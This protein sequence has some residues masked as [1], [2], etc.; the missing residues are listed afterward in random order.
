MQSHAKI[1]KEAFSLVELLVVMAIIGVLAS[2]AVPVYKEYTARA[3]VGAAI[4]AMSG[5]LERSIANMEKKGNFAYPGDLGFSG[6]YGNSG[7]GGC[8]SPA[9]IGS[10][11]G[12]SQ[13]YMNDQ[14]YMCSTGTGKIGYY[15]LDFDNTLTGSTFYY[16]FWLTRIGSTV[17]TTCVAST[18][19]RDIGN[20][21]V[22]NGAL[23]G[24]AQTRACATP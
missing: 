15:R 12:V 22:A 3:K 10:P 6:Y 9:A 18:A 23:V 1:A 11:A 5:L 14:T 21:T 19:S 20:C 24:A 17:Q 2:I 4:Q 7:C 13:L 16:D 8:V